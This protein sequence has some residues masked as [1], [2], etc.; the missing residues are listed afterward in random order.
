LDSAAML[1]VGTLAGNVAKVG[2]GGISTGQMRYV[3]GIL[4]IFI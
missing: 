4:Q 3:S 1:P 2:T